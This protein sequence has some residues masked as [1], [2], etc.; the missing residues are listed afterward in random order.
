MAIK[1][2]SYENLKQYDELIKKEIDSRIA[3]GVESSIKTVSVSDDGYKVYFYTTENPTSTASAVATITLPAPVDITGK[4][5]KVAKAVAGD[6]AALDANGNLTDSGKKASD[7]AS[8]T[9]VTNLT[10][11]V[12]TAEGEIDTL[13]SDVSSIKSGFVSGVKGSAESAYRTGQV[14]ITKENIGLDKVDNTADSTKSV[15]SA[16]KL[17]NKVTVSLTGDVTGSTS[18]DF[19]SAAS[20]ETTVA[21]VPA[22]KITGIISLDN[23]PQGALERC[24][25]VANDTARYA[26]TSDDVQKGDTVKVEATG[27]MYFVIDETKLSSDDGYEVYTAGSATSV[28]WAGITGKPSE[29]PPEDHTHTLSDITDFSDVKA[30]TV[31]ADSTDDKL[32]TAK[33]VYDVV[34][35]KVGEINVITPTNVT[36]APTANGGDLAIGSNASAGGNQSVAI[37]SNSSAMLYGTAVGYSAKLTSLGST[38]LGNQSGAGENAVAVGYLAKATGV[39]SVAMGEAVT[40]SGKKAIAFGG[41]AKTTGDYSIA[42]GGQDSTGSAASAAATGSIALGNGSTTATGDENTLSIG[43]SSLTRRI[44]H[45][46]DPTS[47]TDAA[48]KSYVDTSLPTAATEADI[49]ALFA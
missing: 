13:Q 17:T 37:G 1:V 15:A 46:S 33:A 10:T 26:L 30:T 11:R 44:I 41:A 28:A 4:A 23:L 24:V 18:T 27:L 20:I 31:G 34:A 21:N 43:S 3:D 5:D 14:N 36:T 48:T 16:S 39:D 19:S 9:D 38:A 49:S 45:V 2:V 22:D 40:A 47:D 8:A 29:Y 6:F 25:V 12:T 35:D 42:I 7:F 32:A